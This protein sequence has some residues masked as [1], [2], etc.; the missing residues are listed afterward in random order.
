MTAKTRLPKKRTHRKP[1][2]ELNGETDVVVGIIPIKIKGGKDDGQTFS[3]DCTLVSAAAN[4]LQLKHKLQTSADGNLIT[5]VEFLLD[6][7]IAMQGLG[8]P[9]TPTI[10][11]ALWNKASEYFAALQKKTNSLRS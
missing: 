5:T 8:Y 7:D 11:L 6:L 3:M 10:A 9:S 4:S 2:A 1:P